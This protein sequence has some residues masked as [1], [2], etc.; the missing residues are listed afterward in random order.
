MKPFFAVVGFVALSCLMLLG[1]PA[2]TPPE[3]MEIGERCHELATSA[4][5]TATQK[6]CHENAEATWSAADCTSNQA[7]CFAACPTDAGQ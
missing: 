2:A 1:C 3:C 4:N 6:E 5:A 7:R